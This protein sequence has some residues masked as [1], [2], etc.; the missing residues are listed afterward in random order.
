[1]T[2]TGRPASS[3]WI[4]VVWPWG[5]TTAVRRPC[6]SWRK[7]VVA[8]DASVTAVRLPNS[9]KCWATWVPSAPATANESLVVVRDARV[10]AVRSDRQDRAARLVVRVAHRA[11]QRVGD[12]EGA[13][14]AVVGGVGRGAVRGGH[15]RHL[16]VA[17]DL[18]QGAVAQGV[19]RGDGSAARRRVQVAVGVPVAQLA[20]LAALRDAAV[21]VVVDVVVRGVVRVRPGRDAAGRVVGESGWGGRRT[22]SPPTGGPRRHSRSGPARCPRPRPGGGTCTC[23]RPRSRS[24]RGGR[25][26]ARSPSG[27]PPRRTRRSATGCPNGR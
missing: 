8:P 18:V 21:L 4:V 7:R 24:S 16:Y 27:R 14:G 22:S 17:V 6:S 12:R 25:P 11:A 19:D 5:S 3:Q 15:R 10:A 9:S 1:M 20:C 2:R 26:S 13:V 23:G